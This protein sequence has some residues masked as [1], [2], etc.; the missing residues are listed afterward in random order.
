MSKNLFPIL[1]EG[2]VYIGA[3]LALFIAFEA[4]G[5]S[6]LAFIA[7]IALFLVIYIY[8]NPER[9]IQV[10]DSSAIVSP[11]DG[12]VKSINEY[13]SEDGAHFIITI[14]SSYLDTAVLRAPITASEY[15]CELT[16]GTRFCTSSKLFNKLN[17]VA[18]LEFK[19]GDKS[20]AVTHRL[21]KSFDDLSIYQRGAAISV[22]V[23]YGVMLCGVT[24]IKLDSS[25]RIGVSVGSKVYA[26]QTLL[27]NFTHA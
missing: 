17:E 19:D 22:G 25:C 7:F 10:Y 4:L 16:R 8:K 24:E 11:V 3:L 18:H 12:V 20:L 13:S 23:R 5:L 1:K 15:R 14:E 2:F 21:T 9:E 6:A 27:A 26:S